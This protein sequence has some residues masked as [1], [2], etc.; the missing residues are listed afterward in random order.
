MFQAAMN[1]RVAS[2]RHLLFRAADPHQR[3]TTENRTALA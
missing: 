1:G 3:N 2:V